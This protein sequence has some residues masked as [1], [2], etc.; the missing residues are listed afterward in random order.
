MGEEER[1]TEWEIEREQD[2]ASQPLTM[3]AIDDA[4][5]HCKEQWREDERQQQSSTES[6]VIVVTSDDDAVVLWDDFGA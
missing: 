6:Q 1:E 2:H 4:T 5:I 3:P